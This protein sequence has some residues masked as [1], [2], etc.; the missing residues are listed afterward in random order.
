M[1]PPSLST[2]AGGE[3]LVHAWQAV[4]RQARQRLLVQALPGPTGERNELHLHGRGVFAVLVSDSARPHIVAQQLAGALVAGNA[5]VLMGPDL[6]WLKELVN[7]LQKAGLARELLA[8]MPLEATG[9]TALLQRPELAG[10]ALDSAADIAW[11]ARQLAARSG[12]ILPLIVGGVEQTGAT[13][14][15]ALGRLLLR[16]VGE[17]TLT[18]NTAAAGGNVDLL[19]RAAVAG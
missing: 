3:H 6:P 17:Q 5:V 1:L 16:F 19:A 13:G 9:L 2:A 4:A 7:T 18:V 14:D 12:P 8:F 10:V 15:V 11:A